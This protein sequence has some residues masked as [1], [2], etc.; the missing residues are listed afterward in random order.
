MGES[1]PLIALLSPT[2]TLMRK[3]EITG[4]RRPGLSEIYRGQEVDILRQREEE[5]RSELATLRNRASQDA[6]NP[7]VYIELAGALG[8]NAGSL[9]ILREGLTRCEPDATLY[10]CAID[11]LRECNQIEE[12]LELIRG[13]VTLFPDAKFFSFY[14]ALILPVL[15]KTPNEIQ[16]YREHFSAGLQKLAA[17]LELGPLEARRAALDAVGG[18]RNFYLAYQCRNDRELQRQYGELVHRI[19]AANYPQ[20][21]QPLDMPPLPADGRIRVGYV[22]ARLRDHSVFKDH[23]GWLFERDRKAV[24]V[25]AYHVGRKADAV[26]DEA[27]RTSDHFYHIPR[28]LERTCQTVL[29]DRL[30]VVVFPDIGMTPLMMQLAALRLAPIQCTTWGHPVT[31]GLPTVDYFFS[32]D[33][34]EPEDGQDH[35]TE[36]LIRLPGIG[37]CYRKPVV[38]RPLLGKSRGD[39]GLGKNRHVFLCCQYTSKYLPQND[40]V[41]ARIAKRDP[42]SQF[43]FLV[44]N[45]TV[46]KD[47]QARLERAFTAEGLKAGYYC[48]ILPP[49][50]TL[51]YWNLNLISDVFLDSLEWS[52]EN[53]TL[54]AIACG[55]PVVTLPG[56]FLR[57]RHSYAILTQ[58]GI[59]D[60]IARDKEEYIDIAVRLAQDRG[61]RSEILKRMKANFPQLYSDTRSVRAMEDFFRAKVSERLHMQR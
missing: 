53:T 45:D 36:R 4:S 46:E 14:E 44:G 32:S 16:R 27:R 24:E 7:S 61:W 3:D 35:Y 23:L 59:T 52:G 22:S 19:M 18:H 57:G 56:K 29:G 20:W 41:F 34:M 50:Q 58:L 51:D 6:R 8:C 30:H 15:Y 17:R 1:S 42:A 13:A 38:P 40:D 11:T 60:T 28:D 5:H 49:F 10:K 33:L 48:L 21:T 54:E 25:F 55:L 26:T 9:T 43:V 31:S 12:A 39:F 47:F 2:V 37:V